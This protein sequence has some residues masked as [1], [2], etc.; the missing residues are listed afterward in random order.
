MKRRGPSLYRPFQTRNLDDSVAS[1]NHRCTGQKGGPRQFVCTYLH[2]F[3]SK[4]DAKQVSY[5]L[6]LRRKTA[7]VTGVGARITRARSHFAGQDFSWGT[8]ESQFF[9]PNHSFVAGESRFSWSGSRFRSRFL[10]GQENTSPACTPRA[11]PTA[12]CGRAVGLR[13]FRQRTPVPLEC[14]LALTMPRD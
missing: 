2:L 14:R 13:V 12:S 11:F 1:C 5:I 8:A 4:A 10:G 3:N 9:S 7:I 6:V